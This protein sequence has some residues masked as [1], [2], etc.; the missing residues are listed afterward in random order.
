MLDQKQ[1][2]MKAVLLGSKLSG[3]WLFV[4]QALTLGATP[5]RMELIRRVMNEV[6]Q[7][8]QE[9]FPELEHS[10]YSDDFLLMIDDRYFEIGEPPGGID[11][12]IRK[13]LDE[14]WR[15]ATGKTET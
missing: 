5:E 15:R 14:D 3:L 12:E 13:A 10:L 4:Y 6:N 11:P 1:F 8:H 7:L 2:Q 9:M